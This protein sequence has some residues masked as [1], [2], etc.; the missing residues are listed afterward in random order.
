MDRVPYVDQSGLYTLEEIIFDLR[1]R[2]VEVILV[3]LNEQ[4]CDMLKA[5]DIIPDLVP[6]K[7]LFQN[8]EDGFAH[9]RE[10]L[11]HK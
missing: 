10:S 4:P 1:A 6:E 3:G 7:D 8:I 2:N 5:I 9:L 11:S